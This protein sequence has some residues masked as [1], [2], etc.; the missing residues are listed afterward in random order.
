MQRLAAGMKAVPGPYSWALPFSK[1]DPA[2][3]SAEHCPLRAEANSRHLQG[4]VIEAV[5]QPLGAK[6]S[7]GESQ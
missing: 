6:F 3:A 1:A 4:T 2:V 7:T 5:V